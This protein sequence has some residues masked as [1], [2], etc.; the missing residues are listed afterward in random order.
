[1]SEA[2][3]SS[4]G[5]ELDRCRRSVV[6]GYLVDWSGASL[7][8]RLGVQNARSAS[9]AEGGQCISDANHVSFPISFI[10]RLG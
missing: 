8:R 5:R 4:G 9:R 3:P 6:V 1:M 10:L 7:L 2:K